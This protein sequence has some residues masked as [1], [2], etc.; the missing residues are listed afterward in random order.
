MRIAVGIRSLTGQTGATALVLHQLQDLVSRGFEVDV[1]GER[2]NQAALLEAGAVPIRLWRRPWPGYGSRRSFSRRV[3]RLVRRGNYVATIGH[4][5]LV[6]QDFLF[7][8]NLVAREQE[9]LNV[10]ADQWSPVTRLHAEIARGDN[11]RLLIAN[12]ELART[13]LMTR[14]GVLPQKIRVAYPGYDPAQF[15]LAE[16]AAGR[17]AMRAE[18]GLRDD[19][20]VAFTTSG[21][22][23]LRGAD[24]LVDTLCQLPAAQRAVLRVLVVG[25]AHNTRA[26]SEIFAAKG[27]DECLLVRPKIEAVQAYYQAADL[28]FHPARLETFGLVVLEAAACGTPVLTSHAVGAAELLPVAT[29]CGDGPDADRFVQQLGAL[30]DDP[31]LLRQWAHDQHAAVA[32]RTW[33]QYASECFELFTE[34]GLPATA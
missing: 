4:G 34:Y 17:A 11:Y 7:M 6:E 21:N 22:Y 18:L 10:P 2:L 32:G 8:H 19:F 3:S 12:S 15:D 14:H 33:T 25:A 20:L 13:D 30:I 9:L 27:I 5:D 26:M 24:I 28:L 16:R 31:D 29:V 1:F 23:P